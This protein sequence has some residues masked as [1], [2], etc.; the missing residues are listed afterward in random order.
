MT[1][2]EKIDILLETLK[3]FNNFGTNYLADIDGGICK[4]LYN[5]CCNYTSCP[6]TIILIRYE[7][8]SDIKKANFIPESA[9]M[10]FWAK[11][12][13]KS[14]QKALVKTIAFLLEKDKNNFEGKIKELHPILYP[15][16]KSIKG[17]IDRF[18][19]HNTKHEIFDDLL[20]A[21][22][23]HKGRSE[24]DFNEYMSIILGFGE[25]REIK[26]TYELLSTILKEYERN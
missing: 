14:R 18:Y 19:V 4:Q 20:H 17:V 26:N 23:I 6:N 25:E 22:L 11:N 3:V 15:I 13:L 12:D 5:V 1:T 21:T 9:P 16:L 10:Y 24:K 2:K 8:V 7:I